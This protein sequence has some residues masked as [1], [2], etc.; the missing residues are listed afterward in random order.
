VNAKRKTEKNHKANP[1]RSRRFLRWWKLFL[2]LSSG[3]S[4]NSPRS[5]SKQQLESDDGTDIERTTEGF[6]FVFKPFSVSSET[7]GWSL[8][9]HPGVPDFLPLL[10]MVTVVVILRLS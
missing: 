5:L 2:Y 9:R 1:F 8:I 6:V 7:G 10:R 3:R 4:P